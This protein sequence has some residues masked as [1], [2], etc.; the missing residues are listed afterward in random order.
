[1]SIGPLPFPPADFH[2]RR[3][4][5]LLRGRSSPNRQRDVLLIGS[6]YRILVLGYSYRH[7]ANSTRVDHRIS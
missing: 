4:V 3:V 1:M 6:G 7:K 2:V 5:L